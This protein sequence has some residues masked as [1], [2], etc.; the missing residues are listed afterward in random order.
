MN[1]HL[2]VPRRRERACCGRRPILGSC[3]LS[4][5]R[6]T[7]VTGD[8]RADI[9]ARRSLRRGRSPM[10]R[11]CRPPDSVSDSGL[12]RDERL[13]TQWRVWTLWLYAGAF[14]ALGLFAI[15]YT[16]RHHA[17]LRLATKTLAGV[18]GAIAVAMGVFGLAAESVTGECVAVT[19][20]SRSG[21]IPEHWR[22]QGGWRQ[23]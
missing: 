3:D 9:R 2:A 11:G 16:V 21:D 18:V 15:A 4:S 8:V 20:D 17:I 10:R 13:W 14:I 7:S 5:E 1:V 22:R 19:G 23:G 12:M 6:Q